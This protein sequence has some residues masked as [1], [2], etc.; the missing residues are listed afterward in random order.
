MTKI[1]AVMPITIPRIVKN[2]RLLCD[3][4]P[5]MAVLKLCKNLIL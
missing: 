3:L 5:E 4:N 1:I 2:E